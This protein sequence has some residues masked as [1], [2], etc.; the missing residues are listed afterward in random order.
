MPDLLHCPPVDTEMAF[1]IESRLRDRFPGLQVVVECVD[2]VRV[3]NGS[4]GLQRLKEEVC[5]EVKR[6]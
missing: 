6:K 3:E 2:G 4:A 1:E 5:G